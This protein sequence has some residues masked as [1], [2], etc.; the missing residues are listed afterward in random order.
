MTILH[1][2]QSI[3]GSFLE[4]FIRGFFRFSTHFLSDSL[5]KLKIVAPRRSGLHLGNKITIILSQLLLPLTGEM[6]NNWSEPVG[7]TDEL[8]EKR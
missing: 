3:F 6:G 5:L 4:S 7:I 8:F 2:L 1:R